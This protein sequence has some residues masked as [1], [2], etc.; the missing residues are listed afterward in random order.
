MQSELQIWITII[1]GLATAIWTVFC[2]FDAKRKIRDWQE[3]EA[4]HKLIKELVEPSEKSGVIYLDRQIAVVFELRHFQR[5]YPVTERILNGLID[6]Y[7]TQ[8]GMPE[9]TSRLVDEMKHT[10]GHIHGG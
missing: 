4:Y 3:F 1:G 10:I 8:N 5:Y 6:K 7:N 9:W 2:H